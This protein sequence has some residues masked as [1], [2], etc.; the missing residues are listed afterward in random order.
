[1]YAYSDIERV[2]YF[3]ELFGNVL[4]RKETEQYLVDLA[5]EL[6]K[7]EKLSF[8]N[9]RLVG[10]EKGDMVSYFDF[11]KMK[12]KDRDALEDVFKDWK[13]KTHFPVQELRDYR[14]RGYYADRYDVRDNLADWDYFMKLKPMVY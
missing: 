14:L 10:E 8:I 5:I 2:E 12:H 13:N 3:L 7:Y 6:I 11:S 9:N 1:M 4:I